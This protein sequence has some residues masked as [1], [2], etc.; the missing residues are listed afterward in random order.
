MSSSFLLSLALSSNQWELVTRIL[1]G[2]NPLLP[3]YYRACMDKN[4][5]EA[6]KLVKEGAIA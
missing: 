4:F 5:E 6:K 1:F 2:K 3:E